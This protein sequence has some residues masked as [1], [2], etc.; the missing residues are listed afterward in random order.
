MGPFQ[1]MDLIGIDI[2]LAVSKSVYEQT[3]HD[4]RFTP[5]GIQQSM[6]DS[7]RLGRKTNIGFYGYDHS[8]P[9]LAD[10]VAVVAPT[11]R[12]VPSVIA[13]GD[14]GHGSGLVERLEAAGVDI[15]RRPGAPPG[16]HLLVGG[17]AVVPTDGR[18]AT[19]LQTSGAFADRQV[20]VMDLARDWATASRVAAATADQSDPGS[21][22]QD[23]A[24]VAAATADQSDPGSPLQDL[25]DVAAAASIAVAPVDDTP[26]LVLMRIMAQLASVAAD[27]AAVAVATASDIDLA[28][29]AG[30]NYPEGP[31]EWTNRVGAATVV[32]VLDHMREHYREERYRAAAALRRAALTNSDFR[33]ATDG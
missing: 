24:D 7:G 11:E 18:T 23:L 12:A 6:V 27:A 28:M 9:D 30:T 1:L 13:V 2:N 10:G 14:L 19:A 25:A 21:P 29:R 33:E 20:V 5:S 15:T 8:D 32:S 17:T 4:P 26:A 3:F 22:L 16:G 31:L